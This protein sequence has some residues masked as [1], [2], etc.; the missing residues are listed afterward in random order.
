MLEEND[1][2]DSNDIVASLYSSSCDFLSTRERTKIAEMV[3]EDSLAYNKAIQSGSL[4]PFFL[5]K[6]KD[7]PMPE[8]RA[9]YED[10]LSSKSISRKRNPNGC[11]KC[12]GSGYA[13]RMYP[14]WEILEI[15]TSIKKFIQ[16]K[17]LPIQTLT[18]YLRDKGFL[19]LRDYALLS[20][21]RG[22]V[23]Y[24]EVMSIV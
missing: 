8:E 18:D 10:I 21:L 14:I 20:V 2:A 9:V 6:T 11:K 5:E 13:S 15:D 16:N 17:D 23:E 7:Y 12:G 22:C 4:I 24:E 1:I 3:L 19:F